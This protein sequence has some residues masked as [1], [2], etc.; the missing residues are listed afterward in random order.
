MRVKEK[1]TDVL[2]RVQASLAAVAQAATPKNVHFFRTSCRRLEACA[3]LGKGDAARR[4]RKLSKRLEKARRLA[5]RVRDVDVQVELLRGLQ[6]ERGRDERR[7]LLAELAEIRERAVRKLIRELDADTVRA[8]SRR[9]SKAASGEHA[10]QDR[11]P[12]R[13][14]EEAQQLW[15][16]L[17][18]EFS[19]VEQKNLHLLRLATK[20][21]RYTAEQAFPLPAA[22]EL[23]ATM[24]QA[25]D[26]IGRWHDWM[27]LRKRARDLDAPESS[28]RH[29]LRSQERASLSDAL[30][31]GRGVTR[32]RLLH[33]E[34]PRIPSAKKSPGTQTVSSSNA[35]TAS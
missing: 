23:A 5:G 22:R 30:R 3:E 17:P 33:A 19:H 10:E 32:A 7:R 1:K 24:K 6:L 27:M 16:A 4:F 18:Q 26:A 21:V 20:N 31:L 2:A 28:L 14:W 12:E 9:I 35:A 15:A 13:A 25:Q 34:P 11:F 8:I 29:I